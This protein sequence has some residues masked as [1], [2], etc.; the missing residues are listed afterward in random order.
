MTVKRAVFIILTMLTFA[1]FFSSIIRG[2]FTEKEMGRKHTLQEGEYE[3]GK[4]IPQ[5]VYD[6]E[7]SGNLIIQSKSFYNGSHFKAMPLTK[8]E[9]IYI[10]G[11][12]TLHIEPA[13]NEI[14]QLCNNQQYV[15]DDS[16]YY[17]VG[18]Q[19]SPGQYFLTY[20][21]NGN[22]EHIPFVQTID[23]DS[24]VL[25]TYYLD[26]QKKQID[27]ELEENT[28]LQVEKTMMEEVPELKVVLQKQ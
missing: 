17:Q 26:E 16:G 18:K 10:E 9:V 13:Q 3:V 22:H 6:F 27:I 12:G 25:E 11:E 21:S 4:D 2:V 8:G 1:L 19:I 7:V 5:G 20:E 14:L 15:I 28:V 23:N 24:N